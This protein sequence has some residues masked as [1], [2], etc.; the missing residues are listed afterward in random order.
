[1]RMTTSPTSTSSH[2]VSASQ[3]RRQTYN[4]PKNPPH[5]V[6]QH[7]HQGTDLHENSH[8][9]TTENPLLGLHSDS[10]CGGGTEGPD[11]WFWMEGL[12]YC[13]FKNNVVA[14]VYW[15]KKGLADK[16]MHY[17]VCK[18][19]EP[20]SL[21]TN[22]DALPT[23]YTSTSFFFHQSNISTFT[24]FPSGIITQPEANDTGMVQDH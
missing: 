20:P 3:H 17:F 24:S 13:K 16:Y 5:F 4:K 7:R 14:Q 23:T 9:M 1:M 8:Q 11:K 15:K 2:L 21:P 18:A 10:L 12:C 19:R 6:Q 22:C